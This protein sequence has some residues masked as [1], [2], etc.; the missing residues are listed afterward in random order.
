M[1]N[2]Y[3]LT[4]YESGNGS[5]NQ[6]AWGIKPGRRRMFDIL[7]IE[8]KDWLTLWTQNRPNC[9]VS[10]TVV[11]FLKIFLLMELSEQ[12]IEAGEM[13]IDR[14]QSGRSEQC[15]IDIVAWEVEQHQNKPLLSFYLKV[16]Q[17][18]C[19]VTSPTGACL[20]NDSFGAVCCG[21]FSSLL[22]TTLQSDNIVS[23]QLNVSV[24]SSSLMQHTHLFWYHL[25]EQ[26]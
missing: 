21:H 16:W 12:V 22:P 23:V 26:N 6:S 1:G 20:H 17:Y 18:D 4:E 10:M 3:G 15:W 11:F 14:K 19:G 13:G 7:Y 9:Y 2:S 8:T 5:T 25:T 24:C